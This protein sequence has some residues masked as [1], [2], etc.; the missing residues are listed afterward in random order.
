MQRLNITD[1]ALIL[2]EQI[3]MA[4]F[5]GRRIRSLG[6]IPLKSELL[7]YPLT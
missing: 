5:I 2:E 7:L 6:F 3:I 4:C 1:Q